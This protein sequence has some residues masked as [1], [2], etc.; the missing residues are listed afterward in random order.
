MSNIIGGGSNAKQQ[1]VAASLHFQTSQAGGVIPLVYGT[2]K[3]APNLIDYDDFTA[4][5]GKGAKGKGAGLA[6]KGSGQEIYSASVILGVCQGP[7]VGWGAVWWNKSIAPLLNLP[8][9]STTNSAPTARRPT[10]SG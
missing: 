10:R 2:T 1:R 5:A 8:G 4:S 6:G 3:L 7:V 9:L